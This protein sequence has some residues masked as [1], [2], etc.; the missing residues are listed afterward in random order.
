MKATKMYMIPYTGAV[1]TE[2]N[3]RAAFEGYKNNGNLALWDSER[4][5]ADLDKE[6]IDAALA[7]YDPIRDSDLVEVEPDGA[8]RWRAKVL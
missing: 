2:E 7:G 6:A 4:F 1:D 8:G 3:W 5:K